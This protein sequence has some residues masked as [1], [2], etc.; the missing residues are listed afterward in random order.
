MIW[1]QEGGRIIACLYA[2]EN[3]PVENENV[4]MQERERGQLLKE[5]S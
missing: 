2:D 4:V 3:N 5:R 1:N